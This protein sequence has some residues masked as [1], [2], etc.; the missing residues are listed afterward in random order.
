M[1]AN[2]R[3][4]GVEILIGDSILQS[5]ESFRYMAFVL[6]RSGVIDE[7]VTHRLQVF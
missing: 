5:K 6:P 3:I 2:E 4:T 1:K 7:D